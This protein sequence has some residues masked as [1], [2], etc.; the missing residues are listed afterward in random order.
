MNDTAQNFQ[1]G[2]IQPETILA[3]CT[4]LNP[5]D[6]TYLNHSI[7]ERFGSPEQPIYVDQSNVDINGVIYEKP[8]ILPI[9]NGQIRTCSMRRHAGWQTC[10]CHP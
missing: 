4:T 3:Q 2:L 5:L 8:L 7:I 9:V 1:H 10:I 6:A